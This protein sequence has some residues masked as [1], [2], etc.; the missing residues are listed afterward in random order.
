MSEKKG[1]QLAKQVEDWLSFTGQSRRGT[2]G[3]LKN[4]IDDLRSENFKE[5]AG[6]QYERIL[7]YVESRS[8]WLQGLQLLRNVLLFVPIILTWWG[9]RDAVE[10]FS[11]N[12][13]ADDNFLIYW[14]KLDGFTKLSNI[15]ILDI[16]II[17][18]V[19]ILHAIVGLLEQSNDR[20]RVQ[21]YEE[22]IISLERNLAAHRYLSLPEMNSIV[23][24]T[25]KKLRDT[26]VEIDNAASVLSEASVLAGEAVSGVISTTGNI[27]QPVVERLDATIGNLGQ[28]AGIH[29]NLAAVVQEVQTNFARDLEAL[30]N[31]LSTILREIET[32][33]SSVISKTEGQLGQGIANLNDSAK[34]VSQ[35]FMAEVSRRLDEMN[36]R[37][38]SGISQ[39]EKLAQV[40]SSE[41]SSRVTSQFA[42]VSADLAATAVA[43][44]QVAEDTAKTMATAQHGAVLVKED[45]RGLHEFLKGVGR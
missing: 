8:T 27:F 1:E 19:A 29:Q 6:V 13:V 26:V 44:Q 23:E 28:A 3:E 7:P 21:K 41:L 4:F 22:M 35:D 24:S 42:Q 36:Q 12:A 33:F 16:L 31:G 5:L 15:A 11:T 32:R 2:D 14:E 10:S 20:I 34:V 25:L 9:I 45:L 40:S 39:L 38:A 18:T 37:L 30:K 43:L 17:A